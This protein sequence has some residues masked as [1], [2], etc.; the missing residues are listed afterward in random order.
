[1]VC[2]PRPHLA[3]V[4]VSLWP[5]RRPRSSRTCYHRGACRVSSCFAIV[6]SLSVVCCNH[7]ERLE[8]LLPLTG[9]VRAL[10]LLSKFVNS[11]HSAR[12]PS[13]RRRGACGGIAGTVRVCR[14]L[15]GCLPWL[16]AFAWC[17]G[18]DSWLARFGDGA[19][20]PAGCNDQLLAMVLCLW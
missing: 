15:S 19:L 16:C 5:P 18:L 10:E 7:W 17:A 13:S 12:H 1:V 14:C 9:D 6:F 3:G 11:L 4:P 20:G 2:S 8:F